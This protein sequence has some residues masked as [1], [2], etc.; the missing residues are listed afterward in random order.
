MKWYWDSRDR[1]MVLE[2]FND[3]D[4]EHKKKLFKLFELMGDQGEIR[5]IEKFRN[6]GEQI[7]AFKSHPNRIL[8]FFFEGSKVILTNA[9]EKKADKLPPTEKKKALSYKSDYI[10]RVIKGDYYD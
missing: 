3:L 6:E 4:K 10:K 5:N 7:Y 2:Y 1:S 9:F 8:C